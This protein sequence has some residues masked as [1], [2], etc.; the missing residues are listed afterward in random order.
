MALEL[1]RASAR[2]VVSARRPRGIRVPDAGDVRQAPSRNLR[3]GPTDELV[4]A[5]IGN[6]GETIATVGERMKL[7][8][9]GLAR[10]SDDLRFAERLSEELR[11]LEASEDLSDQEVIDR[12]SRRA[13]DLQQDLLANH[14]G[15]DSSRAMLRNRLESRR[16]RFADSL[17]VKNINAAEKRLDESF[18][19]R[20]AAIGKGI[21]ED[22][23]LSLDD[24]LDLFKKY[25]SILRDEIEFMAISPSKRQAKLRDGQGEIAR[26]IISEVINTDEDDRFDRARSLLASDELEEVLDP[27]DRRQITNRLLVLE[28]A[29]RKENV[30]LQKEQEALEE[31]VLKER[32]DTKEIELIAEI[33]APESEVTEDRLVMEALTGNISRE[34]LGRLRTIL[35]SEAGGE[36]DPDTVLGLTQDALDA[37]PTVPD[38]VAEAMETGSI[39]GNT[40]VEIYGKF[41]GAQRRGGA[42]A[43]E[44]VKRARRFVDQ[45]IGGVRGPLAVLDSA[46][47]ARVQR[48]L[49]DFDNA[50]TQAESL[51]QDPNPQDIADNIVA[52]YRV[53]PPAPN[54]FA[55]PRFLVG[56]RAQPDIQATTQRTL[57]A[58]D[59]GEISRTEA[60]Q[61][62]RLIDEIAEAVSQRTQQ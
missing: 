2:S 38:R 44:D 23:G 50:V 16:L 17:A 19:R 49:R 15:G 61:E 46:S 8:D 5:E 28:E 56:T 12:A 52:R 26:S 29:Q 20:L 22:P 39:S 33:L 45:T 21:Q 37:D 7:R 27:A 57:Q 6:L 10:D 3:V 47:S 55:K 60:A 25:D 31:K 43:R 51:G 32:Q 54:E 62:L 58:L 30:R 4:F 18:D 9:E 11:N 42:L 41:E 14:R 48:A 40:A 34:G 53:T 59:A 36:D 1:P 24:P 13:S 35:D